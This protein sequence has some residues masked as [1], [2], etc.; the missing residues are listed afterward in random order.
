MNVY[1][2]VYKGNKGYCCRRHNRNWMFVPE[3]GQVD[4]KVYKNISFAEILF[5]NIFDKKLE[6][7]NQKKISIN[8]L[9]HSVMSRKQKS[10]TIGG[11]LFSL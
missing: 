11:L 10:Q 5:E 3:L 1:S 8:S 2:C 4:N 7:K 6:E 9:L